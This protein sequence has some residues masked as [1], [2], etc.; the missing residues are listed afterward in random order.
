MVKMKTF[1]SKGIISIHGG[2]RHGNHSTRHAQKATPVA[3]NPGQQHFSL[4]LHPSLSV[5]RSCVI[6]I[7]LACRRNR[8]SFTGPH[9]PRSTVYGILGL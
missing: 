8:N 7:P 6:I 2:A 4:D 1:A 5:T 3:A 9:R